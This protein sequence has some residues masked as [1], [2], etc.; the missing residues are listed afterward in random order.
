MIDMGINSRLQRQSRKGG[1]G[2]VFGIRF[3]RS[4]HPKR[5]WGPLAPSA[6]SSAPLPRA[7]TEMSLVFFESV[8]EGGWVEGTLRRS[9]RGRL[10][11]GGAAEERAVR[12]FLLPRPTCLSP[13]AR[14][15]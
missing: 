13:P 11:T 9:P 12:V 5:G 10:G 15:K 14:R 7:R 1:R 6:V 4:P 8:G 2:A 3:R